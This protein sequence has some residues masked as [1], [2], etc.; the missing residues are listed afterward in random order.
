MDKNKIALMNA[1][2]LEKHIREY[3]KKQRD[4]LKY[5]RCLYRVLFSQELKQIEEEGGEE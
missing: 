4:H 3:D 5:L 1:E 2:Q